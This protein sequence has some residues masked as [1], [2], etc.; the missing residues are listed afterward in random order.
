MKKP[1]GNDFCRL[2]GK[3]LIEVKEFQD[4]SAVRIGY[5]AADCVLIEHAKT[6]GNYL[7]V[8]HLPAGM[9]DTDSDCVW[10]GTDLEQGRVAFNMACASIMRSFPIVVAPLEA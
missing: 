3:R 7:V 4:E 10:R 5:V 8:A 6:P 1:T 2:Y 9:S